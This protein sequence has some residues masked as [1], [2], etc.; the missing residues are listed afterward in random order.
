MGEELYNDPSESIMLSD[1]NYV[2]NEKLSAAIDQMELNIEEH[3][4]EKDI[5]EYHQFVDSVT[6]S[7][8]RSLFSVV[9]AGRVLH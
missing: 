9:N 6:R 8:L 3:Q 1:G 4:I 2:K 7:T 5:K